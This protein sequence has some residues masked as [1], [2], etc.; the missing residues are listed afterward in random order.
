MTGRF[1]ALK[2]LVLYL[3]YFGGIL[4]P[5]IPLTQ[6]VFMKDHGK[7]DSFEKQPPEVFCRKM[8]V[9]ILLNSQENTYARVSSLIKLQTSS[10]NFI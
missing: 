10:C 8:F 2:G 5:T 1:Q 6:A 9:E 7:I 3:R 4:D